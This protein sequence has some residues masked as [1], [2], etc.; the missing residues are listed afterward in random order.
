MFRQ[1]RFLTVDSGTL[2]ANVTVVPA[3]AL[4]ATIDRELTAL[5]ES[6]S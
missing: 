3:D 1:K 6:A 4:R 2:T 5:G